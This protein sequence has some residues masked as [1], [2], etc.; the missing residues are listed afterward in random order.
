MPHT[1][2]Q[3][4][5]G[6]IR[7]RGPRVAA[8]PAPDTRAPHAVSPRPRP[9]QVRAHATLDGHVARVAFERLGIVDRKMQTARLAPS[10]SAGNHE[11]SDDRD[12][13][14]LQQIARNE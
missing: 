5:A 4:R 6:T 1:R 12:I 2:L 3:P 13:A 8:S 11:L 9:P 7:E 14:Q 10:P